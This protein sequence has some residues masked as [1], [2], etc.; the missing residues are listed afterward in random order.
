MGLGKNRGFTLVEAL[1]VL[2]VL[3]VVAAVSVPLLARSSSFARLRSD[4]F[5]LAGQL[6]QAKFRAATEM[7]AHRVRFDSVRNSYVLERR[8]GGTFT[9]EGPEIK[10][11]GTVT[12]AKPADLTS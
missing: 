1:F 12:Y 9:V 4:A 10:L 8:S 7:A 2:I 3:L 6:T 5:E 11:R